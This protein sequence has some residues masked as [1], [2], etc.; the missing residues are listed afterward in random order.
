VFIAVEPLPLQEIPLRSSEVNY[1]LDS[2]LLGDDDYY[3]SNDEDLRILISSA[4]ALGKIFG[5]E[6]KERI[7][8]PG[9]P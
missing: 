3:F 6:L 7:P 1:D 2:E 4:K 9:C 5:M 8:L